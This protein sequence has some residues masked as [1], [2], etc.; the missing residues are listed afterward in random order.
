MDNLAGFLCVADADDAV[1][2]GLCGVL[3][4]LD[5]A[6]AEGQDDGVDVDDLEVAVF[7]LEIDCF[8]VDSRQLVTG[9]QVG[10]GLVEV[11]HDVPEMGNDLADFGQQVPGTGQCRQVLTA[12]VVQ[13]NEAFV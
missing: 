4:V 3:E 6:D 2:D 1:G 9:Q 10:A 12:G 5:R 13:Q 7:G 8:I 11:R